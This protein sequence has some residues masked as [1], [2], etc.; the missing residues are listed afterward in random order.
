MTDLQLSPFRM[1]RAHSAGGTEHGQDVRLDLVC[2]PV[3][4]QEPGLFPIVGPYLLVTALTILALLAYG[5]WGFGL[6][7]G[8][9]SAVIVA[10]LVYLAGRPD[11]RERFVVADGM[12]VVSTLDADGFALSNDRFPLFGLRLERTELSSGEILR[13][14]VRHRD[15]C[16]EVGRDLSPAER[17]GLWRRLVE[18]VDRSGAS[19][20]CSTHVLPT[21]S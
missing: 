21:R 11:R 20:R 6:G 12:L 8:V 9:D 4:R 19:A 15:R 1:S 10:L 13:L 2:H 16:R 7:V 17:H 18:A 14:D 5:L 3:R